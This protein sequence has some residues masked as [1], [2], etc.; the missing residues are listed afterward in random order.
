[1]RFLDV[2]VPITNPEVNV[3]TLKDYSLLSIRDRA[4]QVAQSS[5]NTQELVGG[6]FSEFAQKKN[7]TGWVEQSVY[8]IPKPLNYLSHYP[9]ESKV[10]H[11]IRDGRDVC[12][13]WRNT[14]FGPKETYQAAKY[15]RQHVVE[16]RRWGFENPSRFIEIKYED[17]L[18]GEM[19][20]MQE[21]SEFLN[22][23]IL[24]SGQDRPSN[25]AQVLAQGST[26]SLITSK[27]E[28]TNKAKWTTGLNS[29]ELAIFS[30][31][32]RAELL[33]S[34]YVDTT[35]VDKTPRITMAGKLVL[36]LKNAVAELHWRSI[37]TRAKCLLA[38]FC[39]FR[40]IFR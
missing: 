22:L 28:S 10:V 15:W 21:L 6:L 20:V 13:S 29:E 1:M 40:S 2:W 8:A 39:T 36:R 12:L 9:A 5:E 11:L 30:H 38:Y 26:H 35:G 37:Q 16:A 7:K 24:E 17:L 23:K 14:W 32:A 34:G 19:A 4:F 31:V 3:G 25:L 27:P 33:D 18:A